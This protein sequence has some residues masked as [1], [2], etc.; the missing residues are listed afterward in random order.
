MEVGG[1]SGLIAEACL[2]FLATGYTCCS[3]G[4][5]AVSCNSRASCSFFCHE[6]EWDTAHIRRPANRRPRIPV[7]HGLRSSR[8]V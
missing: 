8:T 4:S 6:Y 1:L 2:W 3:W 7:R 5:S